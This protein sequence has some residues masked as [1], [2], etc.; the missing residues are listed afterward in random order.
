MKNLTGV[1]ITNPFGTKTQHLLCLSF[2]TLFWQKQLAKLRQNMALCANDVT[3]LC[4]K[5]SE[6]M[7]VKYKSTFC[8]ICF[9]LAL[10]TLRKQSQML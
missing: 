2:F 1:N 10:C 3:K 7:L 9:K 4:N 8:A 6:Q 5:I